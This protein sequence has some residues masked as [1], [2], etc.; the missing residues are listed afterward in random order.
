M[1]KQGD[2]IPPTTKENLPEVTER[3]PVAQEQKSEVEKILGRKTHA[4]GRKIK[5]HDGG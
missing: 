5:K 2:P 3:E 1:A 4:N